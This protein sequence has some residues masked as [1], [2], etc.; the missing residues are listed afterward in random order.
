M[1]EDSPPIKVTKITEGQNGIDITIE[2]GDIILSLEETSQ[3]W[4]PPASYLGPPS[5]R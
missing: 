4:S 2:A 1:R 3:D 5:G